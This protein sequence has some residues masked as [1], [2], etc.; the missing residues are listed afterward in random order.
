MPRKFKDWFKTFKETIANYEY[1]VDFKKV[2]NNVENIKEE[3]NIVN[4][5][6]GS[7]NVESDFEEML[8]V[9]PEILKCI[10][11]LLAVRKNEI[12]VLEEKEIKKYNFKEMNQTPEEYKMLMEKTGLFDFFRKSG[13]TNLVDY[14]AGLEVVLD[15]NA[16]KNRMGDL[17]EDIVEDYLKKEDNLEYFKE[18]KSKEIQEK[19]GLD[20]SS[21]SNGGKVI[22][23]FDFVVKTENCVYGIETNFYSKEGSKLNETARSYKMIAE[24]IKDIKGFRFIWITDGGGWQKAK[25]NLEETFDAFEDI[26][27]ISDLENGIFKEIFI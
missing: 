2:S 22:K 9:N 18:M 13:I 20:L 4:A 3:L 17:M 19:W 6:L 27:N 5:L 21:L 23:K 24:E 16:R 12:V 15:S 25:N 10:P 11:I 14:I 7:N 1:Y 8:R 26:Y